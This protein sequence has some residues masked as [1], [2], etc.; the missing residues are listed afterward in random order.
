[1]A[2][3]PIRLSFLACPPQTMIPGGNKKEFHVAVV[4]PSTVITSLHFAV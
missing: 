1:M 2:E 4:Y 3:E